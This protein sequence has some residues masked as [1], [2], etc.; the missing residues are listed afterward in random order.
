MYEPRS[1]HIHLVSKHEKSNLYKTFEGV[2]EI[3]CS[4]K[5]VGASKVSAKDFISQINV[6]TS[7][8]DVSNNRESFWTSFCAQ[9]K[10]VQII[11]HHPLVTAY[12]IYNN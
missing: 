9:V 6:K 3:S 5:F 1:T 10:I 12:I 11:N 4:Y 2:P 7:S 8:Y